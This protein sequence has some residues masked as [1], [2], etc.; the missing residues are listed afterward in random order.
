MAFARICDTGFKK[1]KKES[2][3]SCPF[4]SL[5]QIKRDCLPL[6]RSCRP[7][8]V[9]PIICIKCA[10][11]IIWPRHARRVS[12]KSSPAKTRNKLLDV[13]LLYDSGGELTGLR[14]AVLLTLRILIQEVRMV[15]YFSAISD[16]FIQKESFPCCDIHH[17]SPLFL[18]FLCCA[19]V[20]VYLFYFLLFLCNLST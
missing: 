11:R 17:F 1:K 16:S 7:G 6:R 9:G 5:I 10:M 19:Y 15:F 20:F 8:A 2:C 13:S 4:N 14:F 18:K 3:C 12:S